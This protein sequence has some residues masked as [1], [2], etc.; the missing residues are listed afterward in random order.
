MYPIV[1]Y[2]LLQFHT[3]GYSC[4]RIDLFSQRLID[5]DCEVEASYVCETHH[6]YSEFFTFESWVPTVVMLTM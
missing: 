2:I 6:I 3:V 5:D 4:G 1:F